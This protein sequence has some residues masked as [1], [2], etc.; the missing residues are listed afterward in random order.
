MV[1]QQKCLK[2]SSTL[3]DWWKAFR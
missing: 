2:R 1:Q 3:E